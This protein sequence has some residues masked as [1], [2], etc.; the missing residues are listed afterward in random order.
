MSR[1][2]S[3]LSGNKVLNNIKFIESINSNSLRIKVAICSLC[4]VRKTSLLL[5]IM[6]DITG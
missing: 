2:M 3:V 5:C 6:S 1:N 4:K